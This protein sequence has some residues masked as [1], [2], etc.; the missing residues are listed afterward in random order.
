MTWTRDERWEFERR[1]FPLVMTSRFIGRNIDYKP[2]LHGVREGPV[3]KV[4]ED[5]ARAVGVHTEMRVRV[6]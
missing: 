5:V 4:E 6:D 1:G 3:M 2:G